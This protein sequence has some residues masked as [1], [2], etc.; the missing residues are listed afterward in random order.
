MTSAI[1]SA[2]INHAF[3]VL[4]TL[5]EILINSV[6]DLFLKWE[7]DQHA[8]FFFKFQPRLS[9][10]SNVPQRKTQNVLIWNKMTRK[11]NTTGSAR[12]ALGW[13]RSSAGKRPCYVRKLSI[14]KFVTLWHGEIQTSTTL[15][16]G[17]IVKERFSKYK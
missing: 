16:H 13:S 6:I 15:S 9:S 8:W 5:S 11:A 10:A 3:T 1:F 14:F 4:S 12:I 17:G 2:S 7:A